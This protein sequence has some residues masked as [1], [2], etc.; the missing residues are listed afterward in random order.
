MA[1]SANMNMYSLDFG[2]LVVYV[3]AL[4]IGRTST[5]NLDDISIRRSS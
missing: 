5:E 4:H 3:A 1:E 2:L